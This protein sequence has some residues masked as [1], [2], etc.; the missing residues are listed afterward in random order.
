MPE[1][2]PLQ[3]FLFGLISAA[4]LPLGALAA[5][6]W[7]PGNRVIAAMMAFGGGAL[8]AALTLDLVGEALARGHYYPLALGSL[9]GGVL[10][11]LLNQWLNTRGGFLRKLGTTV[12][13]IKQTRR[14]EFKRLFKRLSLLPL[15]NNTPPEHVQHLVPLITQLDFSAGDVLMK[16]GDAGDALFIIDSGRVEVV[17][18]QQNRRIAELGAADVVGEIAL[19]TGQQRTATVR[20]LEP[21][22][23][24]VLR[25]KDFDEVLKA[26]PEFAEAVMSLTDRRIEELRTEHSVNEEQAQRWFGE[27]KHHVLD[28]IAVPTPQD[29]RDASAGANAAPLAIWLGILLDGIPES[30][31]IGSS[32]LH[33]SVSLSLIAG[34]FLSNFP[35]AFSSSL[36]M[37]E[38]NYSFTRIF[39]MWTSLMLITGVGAWLGS[40]FFAGVD[41][42][43][44]SFL[45]GIAAGAMLTVIAETM[46]PEAYH[47]GGSITGISTL[48]G[49]LV[50]IFFTT[51]E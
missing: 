28:A 11:V 18:D 30:F 23:A 22:Q 7:S 24:W 34:L 50:A 49:F 21:T 12:A 9:L 10:F 8:L 43:A 31:V 44:F 16:Q 26:V 6:F 13:H 41:A 39:S 32:M 37:R 2:I 19:L 17:D 4:S 45:Q 38:Q 3:A 25:K 35:E 46:L 33:A 36:G 15:F 27:A 1:S 47:R 40:I 20:A 42:S 29:V 51:L 48:V 14:R 5:R